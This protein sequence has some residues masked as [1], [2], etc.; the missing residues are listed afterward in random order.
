MATVFSL[1]NDGAITYPC[2]TTKSF[3]GYFASIEAILISLHLSLWLTDKI[4]IISLVLFTAAYPFFNK[5][6]FPNSNLYICKI[7]SSKNILFVQITV[8]FWYMTWGLE[9]W[10]IILPICC[11]ISIK[12]A[13]IT[14]LEKQLWG[15]SNL[16]LNIRKHY[17]ME[18]IGLKNVFTHI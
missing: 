14:F 16:F 13:F 9:H 10:I 12:I 11:I 5:V 18:I 17:N 3:N 2:I 8:I 6:L 1:D 7:F 15:L 4:L